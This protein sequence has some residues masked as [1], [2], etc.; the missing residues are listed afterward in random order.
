MAWKGGG[1][2]R[3]AQ[4]CIKSL[5]AL[6]SAF[7]SEELPNHLLLAEEWGFTGMEFQPKPVREI[8]ERQRPCA[9]IAG[10]VA[11]GD[12]FHTLFHPHSPPGL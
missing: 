11:V 6:R 4:C 1:P 8:R 10:T 2:E 12:G 5:V 9:A 3:C 7:D